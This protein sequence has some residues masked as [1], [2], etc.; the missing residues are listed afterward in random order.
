MALKGNIVVNSTNGAYP[1]TLAVG[2]I[3]YHSGENKLKLCTNASGSGTFV[4]LN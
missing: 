1:E 3:Y 4:D 2:A